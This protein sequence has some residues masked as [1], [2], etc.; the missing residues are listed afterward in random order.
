MLCI[1]EFVLVYML[2]FAMPKIF[3]C[4][5]ELGACSGLLTTCGPH[6]CVGPTCCERVCCIQWV[7][8]ILSRVMFEK[9]VNLVTF[10]GSS[11]FCFI[12]ALFPFSK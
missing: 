2:C 11:L 1:Y 7:H 9:L 4:D 5:F 10:L 12:F 3:E 6:Q 8:D